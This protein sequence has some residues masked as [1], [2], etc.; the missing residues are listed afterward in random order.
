MFEL[1][2][3]IPHTVADAYVTS[4]RGVAPLVTCLAPA[5]PETQIMRAEFGAC[6]RPEGIFKVH[7]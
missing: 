6:G 3:F 5:R 7:A 4:A 1:P 2:S